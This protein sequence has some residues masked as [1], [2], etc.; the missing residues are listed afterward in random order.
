MCKGILLR[1]ARS[2]RDLLVCDSP[3]D[4]ALIFS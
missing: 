1:P 4:G 3:E 2:E